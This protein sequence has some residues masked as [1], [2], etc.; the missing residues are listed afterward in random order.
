MLRKL[1]A[2]FRRPTPRLTRSTNAA[3]GRHGGSRRGSGQHPGP[4][5]SGTSL[6]GMRSHGSGRSSRAGSHSGGPDS[7]AP[8]PSPPPSPPNDAEAHPEGNTGNGEPE[9]PAALAGTDD[10]EA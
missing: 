5:R 8:P 9:P 10:S 2:A 1:I 3:G 6:A 4:R 7:D